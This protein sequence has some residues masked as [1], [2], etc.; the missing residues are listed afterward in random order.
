MRALLQYGPLFRSSV[1]MDQMTALGD[2]IDTLIT[3]LS[4]TLAIA[5]VQFTPWLEHVLERVL[6]RCR[7]ALTSKQRCN[8]LAN[9]LHRIA[10]MKGEARKYLRFLHKHLVLVHVDKAANNIAFVCKRLYVKELRVEL[11]RSNGAYESWNESPHQ[12]VS[13]HKEY[14]S[15]S[16]MTGQDNY[17]IS[18]GCRRCISQGNGSWQD[19]RRVRPGKSPLFYQMCFS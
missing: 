6:Q 16:K 19:H 11:S 14:L 17:R 10:E 13:R 3:R 18:T 7:Q 9:A 15:Y 5:Q 12:I 8:R 2:A 1:L 4:E